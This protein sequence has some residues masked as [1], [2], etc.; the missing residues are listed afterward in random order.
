MRKYQVNY[1]YNTV[2]NHFAE[3]LRQQA[4][5]NTIDPQIFPQLYYFTPD[6]ESKQLAEKKTEPPN[7]LKSVLSAVSSASTGVSEG[8]SDALA[9]NVVMGEPF[10]QYHV[11]PVRVRGWD[12]SACALQKPPTSNGSGSGSSSSAGDP[13]EKPAGDAATTTGEQQQVTAPVPDFES[14]SVNDGGAEPF[15]CNREYLVRQ[16]LESKPEFAE[17]LEQLRRNANSQSSAA[18][19]TSTD[20]TASSTAEFPRFDFLGTGEQTLIY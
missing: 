14:L 6:Y 11:R 1:N 3:A 4:L 19:T 8:S 9:K 5:M 16:A 2:R 12:S 13:S 20:A 10:L 17:E 15:V 18:T 7:S